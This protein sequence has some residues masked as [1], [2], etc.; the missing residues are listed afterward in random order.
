MDE[1]EILRNINQ[2]KNILSKINT[3]SDNVKIKLDFL[4]DIII[5]YYELRENFPQLQKL[6]EFLNLGKN[7]DELIKLREYITKYNIGAAFFAKILA[8]KITGVLDFPPII[9]TINLEIIFEE[10]LNLF[11]LTNE[12]ESNLFKTEIS[13][14]K[15]LLFAKMEKPSIF[16]S[17]K[18]PAYLFLNKEFTDISNFYFDEYLPRFVNIFKS[19]VELLVSIVKNSNG[20]KDLKKLLSNFPNIEIVDD[21]SLIRERYEQYSSDFLEKCSMIQD[22]PSLMI[23]MFLTRIK[24]ID[25]FNI[26]FLKFIWRIWHI[27][28]FHNRKYKEFYSLTSEGVYR[29]RLISFLEQNLFSLC[30]NF[31]KFF[32]FYLIL[33]ADYRNLES[34]EIPKDITFSKTKRFA[35]IPIIGKSKKIKMSI[36]EMRRLINSYFGVIDYFFYNLEEYFKKKEL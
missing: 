29:N 26:K 6:V 36:K 31:S 27:Q 9:E 13:E 2:F 15:E 5:T 10:I 21:I 24:I 17:N 12:M 20:G 25:S 23:N 19:F 33:F 34:H 35:H 3:I 28:S 7:T 11:N 30:P 14:S 16:V 18:E 1:N 8:P 22:D 4:C 32:S